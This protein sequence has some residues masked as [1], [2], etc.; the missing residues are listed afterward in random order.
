MHMD[1]EKWLGL[2]F[3]EILRNRFQLV[4]SKTIID[5]A[6]APEPKGVLEKMQEMVLSEKPVDTEASFEKKPDSRVAFSMREAPSGPSASLKEF[7]LMDN[8]SV[9][10]AVDK[11]V[12]DT[13]YKAA[14]GV[15]DL[16]S[17]KIEGTADHPPVLRRAARAKRPT[18]SWCPPAGAS[19]RWTTS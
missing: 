19:R 8:P 7:S 18:A 1:S 4:R 2:G 5:A 16:F 14:P 12:S 6:S 17:H 15:F 13:D 11:V 3:D 9:P 10:H